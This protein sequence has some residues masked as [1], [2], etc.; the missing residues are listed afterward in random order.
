MRRPNR[1]QLII[2]VL[3][4][5]VFAAGLVTYLAKRT[6]GQAKPSIA[7][8][9]G[10]IIPSQGAKLAAEVITPKG[11]A[12]PPLVVMP[13][14][15]GQAGTE[16]HFVGLRFAQSGYEVV[17]YGQRGFGKSTGAVDFAGAGTQHDV[18]AVIDWALANT[19]ADAS[20]I[21]VLGVSYGAGVGLLAAAHDKR[22]RAVAALSTWADVGAVFDPA[23]TPSTAALASLIGGKLNGVHY[24]AT[25]MRLRNTLL[26]D[27]IAAGA[28][29]RAIARTRSPVTY[30]R[31]LNANR[32]AIMLANGFQDSIFPPAQ[33]V[34]FFTALTTPKRL[35]L[36]GGDH[37]GAELGE[38][39]GEKVGG[40]IT[41]ALAWFDHYLLGKDNGIQSEGPIIIKDAQRVSTR[42]FAS[43]PQAPVRQRVHLGIPGATSNQTG[44]L[45]APTWRA[46]ILAGY[47]S[48]A[49][50]GQAQ[51][52]PAASYTPPH[53]PVTTL[54]KGT[55]FVWIGPPS[56][57]PV[58]LT[59]IPTLRLSLGSSAGR[60]TVFVYLYDVDSNGLGTLIDFQ[61]YTADGGTTAHPVPVTIT[62]QPVSWSI[63]SGHRL[64]LVID[65]VDARYRS[66]TPKNAIITA[67]ATAKYPATFTAPVSS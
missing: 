36:A 30:V 6:D 64:G 60:P 7:S 43:W 41:D 35:Q 58:T 47:D 45:A 3:A 54:N 22:I 1:T 65:S 25:T 48:T 12:H 23:G 62:M 46:Q 34:P 28:A 51:L 52:V 39:L 26:T 11:V 9:V 4:V 2:A 10:Q 49:A 19:S 16:Y 61:P 15:W 44:N 14:G 17:A 59:G 31:D 33:L 55:A 63:D 38:L 29:V 13:A 27:P 5:G 21:A 53:D 40:P 50:S 37:G 18:T 32:P 8:D 67:T 56:V 20:R 66:H 24:D 42:S 57:T